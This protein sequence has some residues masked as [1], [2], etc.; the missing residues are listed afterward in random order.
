MLQI[1]PRIHPEGAQQTSKVTATATEAKSQLKFIIFS[2]KKKKKSIHHEHLKNLQHNVAFRYSKCYSFMCHT[3]VPRRAL[4]SSASS[5][6]PVF[7]WLSQQACRH[8][9]M[10]MFANRRDRATAVRQ[11]QNTNINTQTDPLIHSTKKKNNSVWTKRSLS[12]P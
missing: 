11:T 1:Y 5:R 6:L 10:S 9:C 8:S 3:A 4:A 12:L 7:F 2:L